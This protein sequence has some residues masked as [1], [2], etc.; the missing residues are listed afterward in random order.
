MLHGARRSLLLFVVLMP[1]MPLAAHAQEASWWQPEPGLDWQ[2]QFAGDAIDLTLDVAVYDLDGFETDAETV[3]MLQRR[4]VRVLCYVSVGTWE[5]WRPDADAFPDEVIGNA[6]AEWDGERFLDIRQQE[7]LLPLIAARFDMCRD[8]GFDGIEPDNID[9]Y[10]TGREITGFDLTEADQIAWNLAIADL[11]HERGLAIGQKNIPD[12][13]EALEP[14]FDFAVTEDCFVD[15]WCE[16]MT[17]YTAAGKAVFAIEYT[18]V[19]ADL[20]IICPQA[21]DMRFSVV[22]KHRELDAWRQACP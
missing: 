16:Q 8:K 21:A 17:P 10:Q 3:A 13:T 22:L 7:V 1:A 5:E 18:D 4:D 11:A 14:H 20:E 9:T 19:D 6:W 2:I 12:L 15:G